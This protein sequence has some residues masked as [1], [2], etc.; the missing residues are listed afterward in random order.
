MENRFESR[1]WGHYIILDEAGYGKTK[2]IHVNPKQKLSYQS[3]EKRNEVWVVQQ[4]V[5][6]VILNDQEQDIKPGS[7]IGIPIGTKHRIVNTHDLVPIVFIEVQY[8]SYFG[9]D[10]II[11]YE[12]DY[13][14]VQ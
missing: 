12:D 6:K 1:P 2:R 10:D 14:R 7:I 13:G 9:E 4:G 5:G 3:H 8:G 11:R